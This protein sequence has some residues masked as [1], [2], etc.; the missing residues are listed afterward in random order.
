MAILGELLRNKALSAFVRQIPDKFSVI[1]F[2][3]TAAR[4]YRL[5]V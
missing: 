4:T 5:D 2:V 1:D 3:V